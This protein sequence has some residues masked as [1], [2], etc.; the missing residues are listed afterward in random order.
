MIRMQIYLTDEERSAL[1]A[2]SF[3]T[4]KTQSELIRKAVDD[5]IEQHQARD[6]IVLL[7]QARG[8]WKDRKDIPDLQTLRRE[9]DRFA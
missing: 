7:R 8:I 2:I 5:F 6:R 3:E 4:G 9:F 1:Q